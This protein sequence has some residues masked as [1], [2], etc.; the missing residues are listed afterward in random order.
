[1][2][3]RGGGGS[4]RTHLPAIIFALRIIIASPSKG[5][6]V[7]AL[8]VGALTIS[9]FRVGP[10]CFVFLPRPSRDLQKRCTPSTKAART[11][12]TRG[13]PSQTKNYKP[14]VAA[15]R[16]TSSGTE[17]NSPS[18]IPRSAPRRDAA[19]YHAL[20]FAFDGS[21]GRQGFRDPVKWW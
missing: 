16:K 7:M 18:K 8:G 15:S 1:M 14:R 11:P 12:S 2:R 13:H 3:T 9:A 4:E 21:K 19:A 10:L 5:V 20:Y 17:G 6:S